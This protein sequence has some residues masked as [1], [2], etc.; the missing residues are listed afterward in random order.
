[1]SKIFILDIF[2]SF[3]LPSLKNNWHKLAKNNNLDLCVQEISEQSLWTVDRI[4][5]FT[6]VIIY[7]KIETVRSFK[8]INW[9]V[10]F[11]FAI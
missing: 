5:P 9:M 4:P 8:Q 11:H 10:V 3:H 6:I 7:E 2:I 1:M